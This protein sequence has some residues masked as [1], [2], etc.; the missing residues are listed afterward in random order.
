[1]FAARRYAQDITYGELLLQNEYEWSAYFLEHANVEMLRARFD[2][3]QQVRM[4]HSS[5]F[6]IAFLPIHDRFR[7]CAKSENSAAEEVLWAGKT[8]RR[9][10]CEYGR[11]TL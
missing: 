11:L 7:D 4:G 9:H 3:A 10:P 2:S 6:A 8:L 5:G 1:M